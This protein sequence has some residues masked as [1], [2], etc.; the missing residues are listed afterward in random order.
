MIGFD[1]IYSCYLPTEI[2]S[3]C[4]ENIENNLNYLQKLKRGN[5]TNYVKETEIELAPII[6]AVL[7]H[8][9]EVTCEAF[10]DMN[11]K[12]NLSHL[13][14]AE[15]YFEFGQFD[16]SDIAEESTE[17]DKIEPKTGYLEEISIEV[18]TINCSQKS[19][20]EPPCSIQLTAPDYSQLLNELVALNSKY[21]IHESL[22]CDEF[23]RICNNP[24]NLSTNQDDWLI[25]YG[26]GEAFH[27][28]CLQDRRIRTRCELPIIYRNRIRNPEEGRK[29]NY[30]HAP[31]FCNVCVS[32]SSCSTINARNDMIESENL[33]R[34][35]DQLKSAF[36]SCRHCGKVACLVCYNSEPISNGSIE[37]GKFE[38]LR[39][40]S[41]SR[42]LQ[43]V[44]CGLKAT[45]DGPPAS[46]PSD[47]RKSLVNGPNSLMNRPQSVL[48]YEDFTLCR[49]CYLSNQICATCPRCKQIYHSLTDHYDFG[50]AP[51]NS[52]FSLCPMVSCDECGCW[53]HCQCEGIDEEEY[54]KLG[55]NNDAKFFCANCKKKNTKR[56][57]KNNPRTGKIFRRGNLMCP[58]F[59]GDNSINFMYWSLEDAWQ[60][61][62]FELSFMKNYFV[63]R[64]PKKFSIEAATLENLAERFVEKFQNAQTSEDLNCLKAVKPQFLLSPTNLLN[65]LEAAKKHSGFCD[66]LREEIGKNNLIPCA[67]TLPIDRVIGAHVKNSIS[68]RRLS[69]LEVPAISKS[70]SS[71]FSGGYPTPPF[72]TASTGKM[73]VK[74]LYMQYLQA[75]RS[76]SSIRT[77][78]AISQGLALRP[79]AISGFGLFA[80]KPFQ[81][82]SLIIEYCGEMLTG[83]DLVNKRD[84]YYNLQGKRYQQSCYLFRLDELKVLDAT[85]KGNLS[86]FIN[87]SC[88]PN[89]YSRV[90]QIDGSK[91]LLIFASKFIEA[92]EEILYDYKFPDEEQKI[93]CLCRSEKCRKWMN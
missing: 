45:I 2:G 63:I 71:D 31:W 93:P 54:E 73:T 88:D 92:G 5:A 70:I 50:E 34:E 13:E 43:C 85:H 89:C 24:A 36:V 44:N 30:S 78:D 87:H 75:I 16:C 18:E 66:Y 37:L 23:C 28:K 74:F 33:K 27:R 76:D 21:L 69:L 42:C 90:V 7:L 15:K 80:L 12:S 68:R 51:Y 6:D 67:K 20:Y 81:K 62:F 32:C 8:V 10:Y 53:T 25:C 60:R 40:Y 52:E 82:N 61:S 83:E 47:R 11:E 1:D 84:A 38:N 86:R 4:N 29:G 55:A 49:P 22:K 14:E 46:Q 3:E 17:I 58:E 79:S 41:C 64:G 19:A 26:C 48:L 39:N 59:E 91:K 77:I 72:T 65:F 35:N 9:P 56:A 57:K